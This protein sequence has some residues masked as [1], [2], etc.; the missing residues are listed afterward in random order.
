[1]AARDRTGRTVATVGGAAVVLWLL[2]RGT[3]WGFRAPGSGRESGKAAGSTTRP[4]VW[5]RADRI[6]V[7]GV[8]T[9]LSTVVARARAAGAAEVRATGAAITGVVWNVL[10]TLHRAG[11]TVY[12]T[13]D[14]SSVVPATVVP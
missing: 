5:V 14:L 11:V 8:A 6:E 9:D 7:D 2:S 3:G 13:P 1:M 12:T 4:V 10:Q